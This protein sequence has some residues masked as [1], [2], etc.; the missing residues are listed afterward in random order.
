MSSRIEITPTEIIKGNDRREKLNRSL[1][2]GKEINFS[3][4]RI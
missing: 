3:R 4:K 2:E 1:W